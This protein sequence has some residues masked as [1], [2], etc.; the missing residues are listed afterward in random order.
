MNYRNVSGCVFALVAIGHA[1]R[2]ARAL[3][4]VIGDTAVPVWPSWVVV[5]GA[6]ALSVWAFRGR[7]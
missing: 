6:V 3:P 1:V 5:V 2:A 4:V 7:G